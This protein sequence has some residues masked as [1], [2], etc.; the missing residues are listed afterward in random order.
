MRTLMTLLVTAVLGAA[1]TGCMKDP[2]QR[3]YDNCVDKLNVQL[4]E[5]E[6]GIAAEESAPARMIAQT[7]LEGA[8]KIGMAA[9]DGIKSS[10]ESDPEGAICRAAIKTYNE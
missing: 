9:C 8:R 1:L 4:A 3:A 10:C 7:A 2:G 6:K 5:T